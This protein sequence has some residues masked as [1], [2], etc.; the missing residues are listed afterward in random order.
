LNN[1]IRSI[2]FPFRIIE[3]GQAC[4]TERDA[5]R[6]SG[7]PPRQSDIRPRSKPAP[8]LGACKPLGTTIRLF[9]AC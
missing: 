4:G 6:E 5:R 8:D 9:F 7:T 1:P 3:G 2:Y